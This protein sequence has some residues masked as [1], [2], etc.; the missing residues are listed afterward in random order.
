[1]T[2]TS[3]TGS[4]ASLRAA[5]VVPMLAV[6]LGLQPVTTDL[7]LPALPALRTDL[8]ATMAQAQ[9]TLSGLLLAFGIA[10]LF[11]GALADRH[12]R[13][14]VLL[15][16]LAVYAAATVASALAPSIGFLVACRALQGIGLAA[17]VVC[18]RAVVR[19]L[20]EPQQG[21][22]V[23]ARALSGLGIFA[24][25]GPPV[26]AVLVTTWGW[27]A[28]FTACAVFAA[29]AIA[30]VVLRLPET[31]RS[32]N[33]EATRPAGLL[34][35]WRTIAVHPAFVSWTLLISATYGMLYTFLAGSSFLF[36][37]VMGSSRL[38][39]GLALSC[40]TGAYIAGTLVCHRRLH[41]LGLQRTVRRGALMAVVGALALVVIVWGGWHSP[42]TVTA[43]SM[44][45]NFSHGHQQP[46]GQTAVT[47]PF[48]A[49][50]GTASALSGF[51]MSAT[52]FGIG[53]WLGRAMDGTAAP[54]LLTQAAF[55]LATA[56]VA[57]TLVRRHG[58]VGVAGV[59]GAAA[60]PAGVKP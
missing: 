10:Q 12:G 22:R 18:A 19:D 8:A 41:R 33:R 46:C 47:G 40:T 57:F 23:M 5:I 59:A 37:E 45:L 38:G 32:P 4:P 58:A 28:T 39:F 20:Y 43:A 49:L 48:P 36:I 14:P 42:L 44:C 15:G 29:L 34:R 50:A 9:L 55:A 51:V 2:S 25:T 3:E 11:A 26:G 53:A 52:A 30:M 24:L 31:L 17:A 27:R 16:G 13:R 35:A 56:A 54:V 21:A 1:M 6:L 60:G 7:Y